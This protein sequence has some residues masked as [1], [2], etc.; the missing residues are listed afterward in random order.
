MTRLVLSFAV[1]VMLSLPAQASGDLDD[2]DATAIRGVIENQLDAF[3]RDDGNEAFS[4][5][6]PA[7]QQKFR[8]VDVFMQMVRMG[9]PAV[10][11]SAQ[12]DFQNPRMVGEVVIQEVIVTGQDGIDKLAVYTMERQDDG[13]WRINGCSLF[14]VPDVTI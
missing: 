14:D 7:I 12:T 2:A 8:T 1:L 3:L 9:Y 11:R 4:Y 6:S 10:Y 13:S 5:A